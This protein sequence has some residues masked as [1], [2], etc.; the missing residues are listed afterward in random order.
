MSEKII[1]DAEGAVLG[2][3]ASYAAKQA[4]LGKSIVIV[5]CEK[6]IITG[7]KRFTVENYK[8]KRARGGS[9]LRGPHFPKDSFRIVKRTIRGMLPYTQY[10]G[11]TAFK[12]IICY[13]GVPKEFESAKKITLIRELKTK[14]IVLSEVARE[15]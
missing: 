9:S 13:N 11:L 6:S 7:R 8:E 1:V 15:L 14:A 4:L 2:R 12:N 10:R 3:L 5:N